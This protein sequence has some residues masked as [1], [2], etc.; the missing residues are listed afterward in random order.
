MFRLKNLIWAIYEN[1]AQTIHGW[2]AK[3][4]NLLEVL[5]AKI[6]KC[7]NIDELKNVLIEIENIINGI[8]PPCE[9]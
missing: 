4:G 2:Y 6:G 3:E 8:L 5:T 1:K 9:L 7:N